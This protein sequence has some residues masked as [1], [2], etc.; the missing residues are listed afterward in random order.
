MCVLHA[1]VAALPAVSNWLYNLTVLLLPKNIY[2]KVS[3]LE[4]TS[5]VKPA[6]DIYPRYPRQS[7]LW[8]KASGQQPWVQ[9][10]AGARLCAPGV[11]L[12]PLSSLQVH[13]TGTA[14]YQ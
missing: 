8:W 5:H 3:T 9:L 13:S 11:S 4:M 14:P 10:R 12:S 2:Q 1:F 7:W 6:H